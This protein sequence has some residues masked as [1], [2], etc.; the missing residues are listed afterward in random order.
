MNL[1]QI[2]GLEFPEGY[3]DMFERALLT[4]RHQTVWCPSS[5]RLRPLLDVDEDM[6]YAAELRQ[7]WGKYQF[8]SPK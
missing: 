1:A 7:F 5:R 8:D 3:A 6:H 4:F 2:A